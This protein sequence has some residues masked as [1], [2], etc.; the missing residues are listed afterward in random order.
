MPGVLAALTGSAA[1]SGGDGG[2]GLRDERKKGRIEGGTK[3]E[4]KQIAEQIPDK[5]KKLFAL[6]LKQ[7]LRLSQQCRDMSGVIFDTLIV[8]MT[9]AFITMMSEQT[10]AYAAETKSK[11]KEHTLGPPHIYAMGGLIKGLMT[12]GDS[13]G[14]QNHTDLATAWKEHDGYSVEQKCELILFCRQDKVFQKERR[15]IT[16]ATRDAKFRSILLACLSQVP[17]TTRKYGRAPA[18]FMEREIQTFLEALLK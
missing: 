5:Q 2:Q 14:A 17:Q 18:S 13:L 12:H 4:S 9:V 8:P 15:R 11:G 10:V 7:I 1:G 16:F 3:E 6:M